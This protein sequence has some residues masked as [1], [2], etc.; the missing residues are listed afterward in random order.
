MCAQELAYT[1][2]GWLS[3][4]SKK[5]STSEGWILPT[6]V[7]NFV[8]PIDFW[9]VCFSKNLELEW[10]KVWLDGSLLIIWEPI[11][12]TSLFNLYSRIIHNL[13]MNVHLCFHSKIWVIPSLY[14]IRPILGLKI[15]VKRWS[16]EW[17]M[18]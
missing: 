12:N 2:V 1:N 13:C 5:E 4:Y 3:F 11:F 6:F 15:H 8:K 14:A 10:V 7:N 17:K 9:L 16:F 18:A